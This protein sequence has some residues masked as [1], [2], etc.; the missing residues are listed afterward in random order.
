MHRIFILNLLALKTINAHGV[1]L[2]TQF[3]MVGREEPCLVKGSY[4]A[5]TRSIVYAAMPILYVD[6]STSDVVF[7]A[8]RMCR[9]TRQ[10]RCT[11]QR[12]TCKLGSFFLPAHGKQVVPDSTTG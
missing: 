6:V 12:S 11:Q 9:R 5:K 4:Q 7:H 10:C 3:A 8:R 1:R 2:R